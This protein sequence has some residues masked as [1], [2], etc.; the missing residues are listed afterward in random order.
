MSIG[1][2]LVAVLLLFLA[3]ILLMGW[4]G[5]Q[6]ASRST[7]TIPA[8]QQKTY[9][10]QIQAASGTRDYFVALARYDAGFAG[11]DPD[12]YVSQIA[13]E[14]SFDPKARS[15]TGDIGIAQFQPATAQSLPNPFTGKPPLDA[16]EPEQ[17]L[18]AAALLMA[19]YVH[20]YQGSYEAALAAYNCGSG[21]VD[22][23]LAKGQANWQTY[24]PASTRAY[25][26]KILQE[27]ATQ[28]GRAVAL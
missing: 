11:I 10:P 13:T 27:A 24:L 5:T 3:F 18:L 4:M 17:S 21:C 7:S 16:W 12:K 8:Q 9:A 26:R 23:A 19:S 1:R 20:K 14:S 2:I 6:P 28:Q 15:A 25:V 22:R